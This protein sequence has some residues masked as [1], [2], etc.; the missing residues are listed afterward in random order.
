MDNAQ[1]RDVLEKGQILFQEEFAQVI[2]IECSRARHVETPSPLASSL[3]PQIS[4]HACALTFGQQV[5]EGRRSGAI[6]DKAVI[7]RSIAAAGVCIDQ[8]QLTAACQVARHP[9]LLHCSPF[10]Q[11]GGWGR[12]YFQV[13]IDSLDDAGGNVAVGI[14]VQKPADVLREALVPGFVGNEAGVFGCAMQV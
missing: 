9:F 4:Q 1:L 2:V 8:R 7:D 3:A 5:V 12:Y 11:L 13:T 14:D 6:S 10:M